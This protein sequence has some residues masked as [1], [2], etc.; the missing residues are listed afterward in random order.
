MAATASSKPLAVIAGVG[1]GTGSAIARRFAKA[2]TVVVLARGP[3]SYS[4][5]VDE[6]NAAGGSAVGI[7]ADVT[8]AQSVKSTF[9]RISHELGGTDSP[10]QQQQLSRPLAA[11]IY[12]VGGGFVRKPF[13]DLTPAEFSAGFESNA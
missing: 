3:S 10:Q 1:S 4:P 9:A 11:S 6:I 7:N 12:N 13:L 5:V 8:D 2:Y